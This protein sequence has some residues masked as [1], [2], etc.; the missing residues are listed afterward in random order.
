MNTDTNNMPCFHCTAAKKDHVTV[1]RKGRKR[2]FKCLWSPTHFRAYTC[3]ECGLVIKD[4][5]DSYLDGPFILPQRNTKEL[6]RYCQ[7]CRK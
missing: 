6:L 5:A 3:C 1:Y 2:S 4:A 7:W